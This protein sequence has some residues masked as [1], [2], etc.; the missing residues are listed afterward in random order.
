MSAAFE[1]AFVKKSPRG[2]ARL[3][4]SW[5]RKPISVQT[6]RGLESM[7]G[8]AS[9]QQSGGK[10]AYDGILSVSLQ[11]RAAIARRIWQIGRQG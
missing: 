10:S 7:K 6:T 8:R 5:G 11:S 4:Q 2:S 1:F 9:K 3:Q